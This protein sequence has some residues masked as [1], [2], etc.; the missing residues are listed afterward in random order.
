MSDHGW[1]YLFCHFPT[2]AR[3]GW[4]V[5]GRVNDRG[6]GPGGAGGGTVAGTEGNPC[7]TTEHQYNHAQDFENAL[8]RRKVEV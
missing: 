2:A 6:A 1:E 3:R 7:L 4:G 5:G 8:Q